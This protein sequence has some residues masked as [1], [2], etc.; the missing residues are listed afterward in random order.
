MNAK[1]LPKSRSTKSRPTKSRRRAV[2]EEPV[3]EE[4]VDEEPAD[5]EP[6]DEVPVD[7]EPVCEVFEVSSSIFGWRIT[8]GI[9]A[10]SM[11]K[12][13]QK[14]ERFCHEGG[15][16]LSGGGCYKWVKF[17]VSGRTEEEPVDEE[18]VDEEPLMKNRLMKNRLM[19]NRSYGVRLRGL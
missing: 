14:A 18:P 13:G 7:E 2:D 19:K 6:V 8:A 16:G 3:D 15:G 9:T 1:T 11:A 12:C 4:P 5:E 17:R 10:S